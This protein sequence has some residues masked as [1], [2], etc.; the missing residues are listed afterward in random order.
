MTSSAAAASPGMKPQ[1]LFSAP[2]PCSWSSASSH[3]KVSGAS[4]LSTPTTRHASS[5]PWARRGSAAPSASNV[6]GCPWAKPA[7]APNKPSKR[8]CTRSSSARPMSS[9][10]PGRGAGSARARASA[11]RS[12]GSRR[13]RSGTASSAS[14]M[15]G[16]SSAAKRSLPCRSMSSH[17]AGATCTGSPSLSR[18]C[19]WCAKPLMPA[20]TAAAVAAALRPTGVLAPWPMTK[21]GWDIAVSSA[22]SGSMRRWPRRQRRGGPPHRR[23]CLGLAA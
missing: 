22:L 16:N 14:S 19:G 12:R 11:T 21:T 10:R 8:R 6:A 20:R 18:T 5:L 1:A 3:R 13:R 23:R 15:A 2:A 7:T 17:G 9:G 4:Q